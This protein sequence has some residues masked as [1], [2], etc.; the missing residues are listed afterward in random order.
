MILSGLLSCSNIGCT[1]VYKPKI[2]PVREFPATEQLDLRIHVHFTEDFLNAEWH[3]KFMG[4][5]HKLPVGKILKENTLHLTRSLFRT[6]VVTEGN[7]GGLSD[8][9]D[10]T[11]IPRVVAID[12][13]LAV[14]AFAEASIVISVEWPLESPTGTLLWVAT[15]QGKGTAMI[16]NMFTERNQLRKQLQG[17]INDLF[18]KSHAA[19][20]SSPEIKA[21][22]TNRTRS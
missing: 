3:R 20:S 1:F 4:D 11:L 16:G 2:I 17:A 7:Q 22:A 8:P 10:A 14:M 9:M 21:F 15:I 5:T 6:V 13:T 19:I 12:R 18:A